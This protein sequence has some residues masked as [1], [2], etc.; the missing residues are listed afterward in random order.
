MLH[1][2][3][4]GQ[5]ALG[6]GFEDLE[7]GP[8]NGHGGLPIRGGE[9]Q[10]G[11]LVFAAQVGEDGFLARDAG[12]GGGDEQGA[13]PGELVLG[14]LVVAQPGAA[15]ILQ[16]A[17][18]AQRP[19]DFGGGEAVAAAGGGEDVRSK[20]LSQPR[21]AGYSVEMSQP[22]APLSF[23]SALAAAQAWILSWAGVVGG[24]VKPSSSAQVWL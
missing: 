4:G 14:D 5:L 18:E 7:G 15:A 21:T 1:Q 19:L 11:P 2:Q 23:G 17:Q 10:D 22:P 12:G 13:A 20:G 9:G 3:P 6:A 24:V 8:V 16:V